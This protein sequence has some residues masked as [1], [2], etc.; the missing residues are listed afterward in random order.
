MKILVSSD[1]HYDIRRSRQ[2]AEHL[3]GQ[4]R[5]V[6]GDVLV[7]AGD[8]TG[9]DIEIFRD[10]LRLFADFPGCKLLVLGNHELWCDDGQTSLDRYERLLPD[11]AGEEGFTVLDHQPRIIG[12]VGL[13][14]SIGWYD[15]SMRDEELGIPLEFYRRK[16]SPGAA[17]YYGENEELLEAHRHELTDSQMAVGARWMDGWRIHLGMSDE[18]FL[19]RLLVRLD[20]Q[21]TEISP[22][23]DRIIAFIHHLPF[24]ELLPD[25][26]LP[27]RFRFAKA[28]LGSTRIG[29]ALA[30]NPKVTDVF[31][32]HS[33]W[34]KH[35][36]IGKIAAVNNG[37]TYIRKRLDILEI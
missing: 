4:V 13:V 35:A 30:A 16:I 28:F 33:H 27:E 20:E 15:Y 6:G 17:K 11:L 32:G 21:L 29:E 37:S 3:A 18:E 19:D 23:V 25:R 9:P 1:L 36:S 8:T 12:R 31:C 22:R 26:H 34:P 5:D 7:L 2:P 24:A 14:G 10:A